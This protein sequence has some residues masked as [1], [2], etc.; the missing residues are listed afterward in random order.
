MISSKI[1]LEKTGISRATLN[2][3]IKS[4]L[5][6]RPLV[7]NPGSEGDGPRQLGYFPDM[8]EDRIRQI[9]QLKREGLSMVEIVSRFVSKP[10]AGE[11]EFSSGALKTG[12]VLAHT[13]PCLADRS[14]AL[15]GGGL[16]LTVDELAHPAYMLNYNFELIWFNAA[17]QK[18]VFGGI[19]T[20]PATS[21]ERNL[22]RLISG[23]ADSEATEKLMRFHVRLAKARIPAS[24]FATLCQGVAAPLAAHLQ[25]LFADAPVDAPR[26]MLHVPL[27]LPDVAENG[28]LREHTAYA[29]FFREGVFIVDVPEGSDS[30]SLLDFLARRDEVIRGLL[31]RRLPVL[32]HLAVMVAD[33]QGSVRICSEMP[34]EEYFELINEIW[35]AMGP[36]FRRYHGTYAKH[37]GDGMVYYFFP[38]PD[39]DYI[40]NA[41]A[42]AQELKSEIRKISKKWQLRKNWLNELYLN[43]GLHE[44]QEW[45]GTFQTATSVEF[46]VLGDTIN[47]AS[48]LS[49]FARFGT[50]WATKNLLSKLE[51]EKRAT[52]DFGITRKGGD[53]QEHFV[54]SSYSQLG[55]MV[56]LSAERHEKLRDIAM[57][58]ITEIR[59]VKLGT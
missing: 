2:N 59:S 45:L 22:F 21:A 6:A 39:S 49:E 13:E 15:Q 16:Q 18:A 47:H 3:Y 37:V 46:A 12:P 50:I 56:D 25:E 1:L 42:C 30:D 44:G 53:G 34:P 57:L 41:L 4:G 7:M 20:L 31:K 48:R 19:E 38:Q 32:T 24:H 58:P 51:H 55:S 35:A 14:L 23:Q 40:F 29:S 28:G 10:A 5:V 33:L 9:R 52:V 27:M 17:A 8:V 43:T 26:Q 36:I 11:P 54:A